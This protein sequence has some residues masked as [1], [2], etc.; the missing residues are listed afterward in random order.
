MKWSNCTQAEA[1]EAYDYAKSRYKGA[2]EEY[3]YNKKKID[4][5]YSAYS[6][7]ASR[8]EETRSEK[9]ST[10]A[11][12]R[13]Q[14]RQQSAAVLY[15]PMPNGQREFLFADGSQRAEKGEGKAG[16]G[17]RRGQREA[18]RSRAGGAAAD[19]SDKFSRG[20]AEQT[21]APDECLFL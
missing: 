14:R 7:M 11:V 17:A 13:V 6:G 19:Q 20:G 8:T 10:R 18:Q 5:C 2:A 1:Q 3:L 16:A 15:F 9:L 4:S 12:D 21:V